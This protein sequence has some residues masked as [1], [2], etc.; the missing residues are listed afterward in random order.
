[1]FHRLQM[2][3]NL[4]SSNTSVSPDLWLVLEHVARTVIILG[5]VAL[6]D[7]LLYIVVDAKCNIDQWFH[8]VVLMTAKR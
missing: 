7:G 2:C 8:A 5:D 4:Q 3:N 6:A 1:M